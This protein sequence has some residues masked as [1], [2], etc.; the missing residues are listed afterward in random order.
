DY[1]EPTTTTT[2]QGGTIRG[3]GG[4][5]PKDANTQGPKNTGQLEPRPQQNTTETITTSENPSVPEKIFLYGDLQDDLEEARVIRVARTF[6]PFVVSFL[7]VRDPIQLRTQVRF[8]EVNDTN[9]SDAGFFW[10]GETGT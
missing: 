6:C 3:S 1:V 4:Q 5:A 7:T 10:T 2:P 8:M 9:T